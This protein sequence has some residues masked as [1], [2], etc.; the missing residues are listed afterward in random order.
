M[1]LYLILLFTIIPVTELI[2]LI[3][4]SHTFGI[5]NTF[6]LVVG[7]GVIGAYIAR[8]Q[9][10][11]ILK[12]IQDQL[13]RG[14]MPTEQMISGVMLLV[15]GLA[16]LTPGLLTDIFG[17]L[18]LFPITRELIKIWLKKK[19]KNDLSGESGTI[20]VEAISSKNDDSAD[21]LS[22]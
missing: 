11:I 8:L 14:N 19:L 13:N 4:L 9:G 16:L 18:L 7:T 20:T 2:I 10:F 21:S 17:L 5:L 6:L 12:D 3:N 15:G 1:F 22:K